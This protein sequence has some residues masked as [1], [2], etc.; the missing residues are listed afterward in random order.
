MPPLALSVRVRVGAHNHPRPPTNLG[1]IAGFDTNFGAPNNA[2]SDFVRTYHN[3]GTG[4]LTVSR[5]S[6][7]TVISSSPS[8][9]RIQVPNKL[10]PFIVAMSPLLLYW[11]LDM[12]Y[13]YPPGEGL[14]RA[15]EGRGVATQ[16]AKDPVEPKL[17]ETKAQNSGRVI[18]M[19][20][21]VSVLWSSLDILF[22]R[23]AIVRTNKSFDVVNRLD[24]DELVAQMGQVL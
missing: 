9:K 21:G 7:P 23:R 16:A 8:G 6:R 15:R 5:N 22:N 18:F 12:M 13:D 1:S 4:V 10:K 2:E 17:Q 14:A 24:D 3:L 20:L 11:V 19:F